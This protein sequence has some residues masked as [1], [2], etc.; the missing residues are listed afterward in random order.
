MQ[1]V[2]L[3]GDMS[4]LSTNAKWLNAF[5]G[6]TNSVVLKARQHESS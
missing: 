5:P 6:S 4:D 2:K 3:N 1:D